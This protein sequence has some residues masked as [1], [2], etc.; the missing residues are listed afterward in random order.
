[1]KQ[2]SGSKIFRAGMMVLV[3]AMLLA[4]PMQSHAGV[5]ISVGIAPPIMPVYV[6]PICPGPDYIWTPGYWAYGP[7][8]YYWVPGTWVMAPEP[9]FLWTPGYWGW[10]DGVY[11]WHA[12]YWGRHIGFYG[13]VNYGFGYFGTGFYGGRWEG[14]HFMYNT[15]YSHVNVNII[16][17]TYINRTTVV[18]NSHVAFN[19]GQ[20]G[21]QA[22]A[23]QQEMAAEHENHI[24]ATSAQTAHVNAAAQDRANFASVNHGVPA[25]AATS[26]PASSPND[27]SRSSVPARSNATPNNNS[28]Q[29]RGGNYGTGTT[30][31]NNTPSNT[32]TNNTRPANTNNGGNPHPQS[33]TYQPQN[34]GGN[35][36]PNNNGGG[37]PH[38]NPAPASHAAPAART[39]GGHGEE[40]R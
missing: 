15:A 10:G 37:Q 34:N 21:I 36:H 2:F 6:Q 7:D 19:G 17:N 12:G 13:G 8:G 1:M 29:N 35:Q 33:N 39:A 14:G 32:T 3:A 30:R 27:F 11:L 20:G 4:V 31:P 18:N 24:N 22:R 16:H 25:H 5:F 23:S 26:R 28:Q 40:H 38:N 9:G